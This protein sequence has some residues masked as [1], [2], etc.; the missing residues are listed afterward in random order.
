MLAFEK[1][2]CIFASDCNEYNIVPIIFI[3]QCDDKIIKNCL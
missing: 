1:N 3:Q 2:V